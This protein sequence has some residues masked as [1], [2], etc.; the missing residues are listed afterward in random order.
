MPA[1]GAICGRA[2]IGSRGRQPLFEGAGGSGIYRKNPIERMMRDVNA[3]AAHYAFTDD[4][5]APNYGRALLG[6]PPARTNNFV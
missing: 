1:S 3:G 4:N 5:S 2:S 6:L